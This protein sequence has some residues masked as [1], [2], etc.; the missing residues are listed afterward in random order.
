[1]VNFAGLDPSAARDDD[2]LAR[3]AGE[4]VARGHYKLYLRDG[5]P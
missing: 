5:L 4:G 1:M 2:G 3:R